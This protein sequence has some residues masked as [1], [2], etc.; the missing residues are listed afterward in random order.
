[1][2]LTEDENNLLQR[3][4]TRVNDNVKRQTDEPINSDHAY[5]ADTDLT[6]SDKTRR[7]LES[8]II[9]ILG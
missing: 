6:M 2:N 5:T 3:I 1:M 4:L 9:K 8:L 7:I